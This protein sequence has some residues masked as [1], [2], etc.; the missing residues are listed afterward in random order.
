MPARKLG[1]I[2]GRSGAGK[3]TLLQ[4]VAG[5]TAPTSGSIC[6]TETTGAPCSSPRSK[7][8]KLRQ[9]HLDSHAYFRDFPCISVAH[10]QQCCQSLAGVRLGED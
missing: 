10:G 9:H 5:L 1:L 3:T 6:I 8:V 7:H 2:Y 4:L